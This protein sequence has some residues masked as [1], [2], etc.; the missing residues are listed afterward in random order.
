MEGKAKWG[1]AGLALGLAAALTLPTFAQTSSPEPGDLERTVSVTG[2]ATIRSAPDEAVVTL[3]VRTQGATAGEAMAENA[4]AMS[5]VL[6]AIRSEGIG[7]NDLATTSISLYPSYSDHGTTI[8]G[9]VAENQVQVTVHDMSD[10]GRV[11]DRAVDAGANTTNG[12]SFQL[13]DEN[14]G[15]DRALEEAVVDARAKAEVLAAAGGASLGAVVQIVETGATPPP[16]MYR[17]YAMAE[18]AGVPPVEAPTLEREITVSVVWE[19]V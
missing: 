2:Q 10:I 18:A 9:Y 8:V 15:L 19:L 14:Q 13:S 16:P 7:S 12:I 17:D 3:G 11:I 5:D 4:R 1:L 6:D